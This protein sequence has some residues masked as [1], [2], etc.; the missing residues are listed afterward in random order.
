[1]TELEM[2]KQVINDYEVQ[3]DNLRKENEYL[4]DLLYNAVLQL[5]QNGLV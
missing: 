2:L 5:E 3:I 4:K 1:M